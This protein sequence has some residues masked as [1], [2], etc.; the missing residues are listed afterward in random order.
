M[1]LAAYPDRP[2]HRCATGCRHAPMPEKPVGGRCAFPNGRR[3]G[4]LCGRESVAVYINPK[5]R[6]RCTY[7]CADHDSDVI[8]EEA[9]KL[10]FRRF[11][12]GGQA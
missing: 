11:P 7:R 5:A 10:G 6:P 8:V 1:T 2:T 12:V 4:G 9:A 3:S